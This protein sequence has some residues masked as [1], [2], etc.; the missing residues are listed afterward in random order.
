[1]TAYLW[2]PGTKQ[3]PD[4]NNQGGRAPAGPESLE[5]ASASATMLQALVK[6]VLWLH[7]LLPLQKESAMGLRPALLS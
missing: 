5:P 1:M 4:C 7:V 3:L 6:V 2:A